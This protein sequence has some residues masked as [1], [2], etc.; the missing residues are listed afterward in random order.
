MNCKTASAAALE[1]RAGSSNASMDVR[2]RQQRFAA[3]AR[4]RAERLVTAAAMSRAD[5]AA[6]DEA[7][8][9][10]PA[11]DDQVEQVPELLSVGIEAGGGDD[12]ALDEQL[13]DLLAEI[14][15][16]DA[17]LDDGGERGD[18]EEAERPLVGVPVDAAVGAPLDVHT[19][20][21][22]ASVAVARCLGDA[23]RVVTAY[24]MAPLP[25]V[26]VQAEGLD[27]AV[28]EADAFAAEVARL[29]CRD[30]AGKAA[31][32]AG[33]TWHAVQAAPPAATRREAVAPKPS[34][35]TRRALVS[36]TKLWHLWRL[37]FLASDGVEIA[38][39]G[40]EGPTWY[41]VRCGGRGRGREV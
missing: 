11:G 19:A 23:R 16:A 13:A 33:R 22:A 14:E 37:K 41:Q 27:A 20:E 9:A 40:G 8:E 34:R 7:G 4:A 17:E 5:V 32:E 15:V 1:K 29:K 39:A 10:A 18:G 25:E 26:Q 12:A 38:R 6:A 35:K 30:A 24:G 21:S 31:A 2:E 36:V 28:V 3:G